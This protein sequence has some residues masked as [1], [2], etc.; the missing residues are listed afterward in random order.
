MLVS[1]SETFCMTEVPHY[2]AARS[3]SSQCNLPANLY[4]TSPHAEVYGAKKA[5][6]KQE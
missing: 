1:T 2:T 5:K 6:T 4:L 3:T